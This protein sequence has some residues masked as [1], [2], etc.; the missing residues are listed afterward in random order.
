LKT[1]ALLV[2][3]AASSLTLS[4]VACSSGNST[5][6][7]AQTVQNDGTDAVLQAQLDNEWAIVTGQ[8]PDTTRPY[9]EIVRLISPEEFPDT[10]AACLT[11]QGYVA[12]V[13]DGGVEVN[14]ADSQREAL[15]LA[16]YVC[17]AE[18]PIDPKYTEPLTSPQLELLYHYYINTLTPCLEEQG[19]EPEDPPS[20][21][22]FSESYESAGAW[23]PY[24]NITSDEANWSEINKLCPPAPAGL[25]DAGK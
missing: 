20:F 8:F 6:G 3:A 9:P 2:L 19:L 7:D 15:T 13:E 21:Q 11:E 24:K 23:T 17:S 5:S 18:Y 4:L 16:R 14:V 1:R 22:T 12:T 10:R 25:F